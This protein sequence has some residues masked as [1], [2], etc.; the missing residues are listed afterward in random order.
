MNNSTKIC[1]YSRTPLAAAP[2]EL[3]KALRKYTTLDVSYVNG[4]NRYAD[5]REFPYHLLSGV[6]NG[7]AQSV[8]DESE[9][10]HVHNYLVANLLESRK[11]QKVIAQF[12]SLPRQGNWETLMDFADACYTIR[13][14]LQ[15]KEY[16]LPGLPNLIDP[17]EYIPIPRQCK[18]KIAFA[19]TTRYPIEHPASKGYL[20]V[21]DILNQ[22]ATERDVDIMWIERVNYELNLELKQKCHILIDDVV[23]GN[24]HR[25]SLEGCCFGSAVINKINKVPFVSASLKNLHQKLLWLIDNPGVLRDYQERSRLWILQ[26]WHAM[27]LV[28]AY[29]KAYEGVLNV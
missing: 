18:I 25:T 27:D 17:D 26:K 3:F 23:T 12:H 15:E 22:I 21:R 28:K 8:L 1:L 16:K 5:G 9:I 11:D 4:R 2:W 7:K 6:H 20:E 24:W 14:P 10:W 13:Q 19:P 29:V